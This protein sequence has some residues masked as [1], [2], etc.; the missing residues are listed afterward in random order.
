MKKEYYEVRGC[1][2]AG[3]SYSEVH[4]KAWQIYLMEKKKSKRRAY[5][6]SAYFKKEK[7]F[8]DIFWS[9]LKQKSPKDKFRRLKFYACAI[10]LLK[11][12]KNHPV[13]VQNVDNLSVVFHRFHGKVDSNEK[14]VVQMKENKR[15]RKKYLISVFPEK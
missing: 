2:L 12:C 5:V 9:H 1:K 4:K 3:T 13:T 7:I 14:F 11:K 15:T 8:L 10:K 6:R